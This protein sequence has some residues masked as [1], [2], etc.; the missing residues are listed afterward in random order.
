MAITNDLPGVLCRVSQMASGHISSTIR[1][2]EG[3][4]LA[5]ANSDD[6]FQLIAIRQL[7]RVKSTARNDLAVA[8]QSDALASVAQYFYQVGNA[9]DS[10]K[11]AVCAVDT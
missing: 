10:G 11:L 2:I 1:G 4:G 3:E 9:Y 8:L 5:A 6:H 7:L